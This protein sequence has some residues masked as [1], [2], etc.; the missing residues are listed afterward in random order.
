MADELLRT[1]EAARIIGVTKRTLYRWDEQGVLKPD[2]RLPALGRR[3]GRRYSKKSIEVFV[4]HYLE[5]KE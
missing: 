5:G 2:R 1:G 4:K 3:G